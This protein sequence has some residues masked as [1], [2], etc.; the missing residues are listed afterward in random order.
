M[1]FSAVRPLVF[2][3]ATSDGFIF[4]YDL[5]E[6][7][8]LPVVTLHVSQTIASGEEEKKRGATSKHADIPLTALAF[9]HKQ[10]DL[11]AACDWLGR[12]HVWK[13][14]WRLCNRQRDEQQMLDDLGKL[15]GSEENEVV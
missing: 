13:L 8:L 11:I 15:S 6:S 4:I 3:V 10:R 9:N 7:L 12:I 2:A 1:K 5:K 14:S